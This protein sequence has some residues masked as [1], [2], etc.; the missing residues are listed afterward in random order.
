MRS[1]MG[2]EVQGAGSRKDATEQRQ[3]AKQS[4]RQR[5]GFAGRHSRPYQPKLYR[6]MGGFPFL[7][8]IEGIGMEGCSVMGNTH[9][10]GPAS[11][12]S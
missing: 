1:E 2:K 12:H 10:Q 6:L 11:A 9:F 8:F 5:Y 7:V 4:I 3:A